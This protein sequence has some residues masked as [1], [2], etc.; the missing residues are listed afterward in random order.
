MAAVRQ[1]TAGYGG[2]VP[3]WVA[4]LRAVNLGARNKVNMADLRTSLEASGFDDVQTYLQSGNVILRSGHRRPDAAA[5]GVSAVVRAQFGLDTPVVVRRPAE[6]ADLVA[7]CPF[8]DAAERPTLTHVV[9]LD[10][11]PAPDAAA[12]LES[13]DVAPDRCLRH[14]AHVYVRYAD[15]VQG[16]KV[17]SALK[18]LGVAGT[19]RN[20]R[21][22][23]ALAELSGGRRR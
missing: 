5:A 14:G 10:R 19:A 3:V 15:A 23:V 17:V 18:R 4:L 11:T 2:R 7:S 9:F 20:W 6:L 13:A 16:N 22:V 12:A 21:T 1:T 8:P